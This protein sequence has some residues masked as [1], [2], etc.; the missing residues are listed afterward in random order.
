MTGDEVFRTERLVAVRWRDDHAPVAFAAYSQPE[1]V[2]YLG[3]PRLPRVPRIGPDNVRASGEVAAHLLGLGHRRLAVI[4]TEAGDR[5]APGRPIFSERVSGFV[6][7]AEQQGAQVRVVFAGDNNRDA[8]RA[9][10][11]ELLAADPPTAVFA[12]TDILAFGVLDAAAAAG[13]AVPGRLSVAGF[14]DIA[15]AES[16]GLTTVAHDLFGQ[17]RAAARIALRRAGGESPRPP[18]IDAALVVRGSTGPA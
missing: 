12:V 18:R 13:I 17:G 6:S 5:P 3:N 4:T 8:G 15:A 1:F 2:R 16:A 14:D 10:A 9:A 7:T 11:V